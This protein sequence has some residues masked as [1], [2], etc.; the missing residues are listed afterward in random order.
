[1]DNNIKST[2]KLITDYFKPIAKN[3][4]PI[5]SV[6]PNTEHVIIKGYNPITNHYHCCDCG[7]D[8]GNYEGQLCRYSWCDGIIVC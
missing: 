3:V 6:N 2:N 8:M 4:I 5:T 7:V 1:M